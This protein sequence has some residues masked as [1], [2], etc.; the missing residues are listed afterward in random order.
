[1]NLLEELKD[2]KVKSNSEEFKEVKKFLKKNVLEGRRD[3][4]IDVMSLLYFSGVEDLLKTEGLT[5]DYISDQREGD[6]IRIS[7][8]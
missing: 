8:W 3:V 2:L 6:F 1:M 7:G 5:V 4:C